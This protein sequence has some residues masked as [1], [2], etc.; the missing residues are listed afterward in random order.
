MNETF[1]KARTMFDRMMEESLGRHTGGSPSPYTNYHA[2]YRQL[3][4]TVYD[5]QPPYG[6][7][8]P[9]AQASYTAHLQQQHQP[10][11]ESAWGGGAGGPVEVG[12]AWAWMAEWEGSGEG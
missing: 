8:Q 11:P 9:Q 2:I 5:P 7:P 6:R 10:R 12:V 3:F 4:P 1:V